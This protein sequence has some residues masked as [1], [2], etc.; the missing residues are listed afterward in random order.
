MASGAATTEAAMAS[1]SAA[2]GTAT[3]V[4]PP[5]LS[6]SNKPVVPTAY[7]W[8]NGNSMYP[9]RRHTGESL[10]RRTWVDLRIKKESYI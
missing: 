7:D 2:S 8:P 3:F 6:V 1:E 9:L 10:W 4:I 5:A